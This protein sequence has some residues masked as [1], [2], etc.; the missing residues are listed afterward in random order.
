MHS[1]EDR[2]NVLDRPRLQCDDAPAC[3]AFDGVDLL[4]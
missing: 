4:V 3:I 1:T 2:L